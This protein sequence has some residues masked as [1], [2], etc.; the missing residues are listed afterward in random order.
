MLAPHPVLS[1]HCAL[2]FLF[3]KS[4]FTDHACV[5]V[6]VVAFKYVE[7]GIVRFYN[8]FTQLVLGTYFVGYH[9]IHGH[10]LFQKC[11]VM[12]FGLLPEGSTVFLVLETVPDYSIYY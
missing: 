4:P 1:F 9:T 10:C 3:L 12:G 8:V 2:V 5:G 7:K 6:G 11:I